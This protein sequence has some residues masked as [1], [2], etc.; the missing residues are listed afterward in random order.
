MAYPKIRLSLRKKKKKER[1][2]YL[3]VITKQRKPGGK[4]QLSPIIKENA[5]VIYYINGYLERWESKKT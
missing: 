4:K 3:K 2:P 5:K 1:Y